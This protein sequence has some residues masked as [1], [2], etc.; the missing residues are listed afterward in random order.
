MSD[1]TSIEWTRSDDGTPGATWNPVTGCTKISKGCDNCYA[2]TLAERFRG[3][4]GHYFEGG[5]DVQL[6]DHKLYEPIRWKKPRRIF[7]NSMS[8]LFHKD[9]PTEYIARVFAV[10]ALTPQHTYQLLTKRHGRMRALLNKPEFWYHVGRF[11][12]HIGYEYDQAANYLADGRNIYDTAVWEQ[13]RFL[14]NAWIG[15]SVEDQKWADIRIPALL[16]TPAAIR[17]LSCE[18]LVGPINF[19]PD[20]HTGHE[21][22]YDGG[23]E[24]GGYICLDCSTDEQNVEWT[25]QEFPPGINWV[26]CGG[27]SGPGSRPMDLSWAQSIVT[28]CRDAKVPVFVK[29]L[30]TAWARD[31]T[32]GGKTIAAHGDRKGSE[33]AHWPAELRIREFPEAPAAVAR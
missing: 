9:V 24:G 16:D 2:E 3:T 30:G 10:M 18:P 5:F 33:M 23:P 11:A 22:D 6:R 32:T 17:F 15:A 20:D 25:T 14:P 21:R 26:I 8:D 13:L 4:P 12:R 19:Q 29:Q 1:K 7:V 28:Q 27:E 31:W